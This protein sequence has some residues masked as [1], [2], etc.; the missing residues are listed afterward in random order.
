ML[1]K[2]KNNPKIE[3]VLNKV[4][5]QMH[6]EAKLDKLTLKD[7]VSGEKSELVVDGLFVAIGHTPNS[8]FVGNLLDKD[9]A[10]YLL[11]N[12]RLPQEQR[13]SKYLMGTKIEGL[14]V[15]GDIEDNY[16]RQA[17]SAAGDGCRAAIECERWLSEK[18]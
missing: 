2:S 5:D 14:F 9:E 1:E 7:T 17:I 13:T 11:P 8:N 3:F 4:V 16:Y 10:G 12:F 18:E 15:A 6:G